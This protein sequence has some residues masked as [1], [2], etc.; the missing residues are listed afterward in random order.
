VDLPKYAKLENERRFLV[1]PDAGPDLTGAQFRLIE[2]LY[3][4]DSRLRL[5]ATTDSVTGIRELKFCK[6]YGSDDPVSG[7]ITNLYLTEAEHA[8][9]AV[10]PGARI[11]KRR[12]RVEAGGRSFGLDVFL[13]ALEGL[14]LCE[15]EAETRE[16]ALA[17]AFP[18][19]TRREVTHDPFFTGGSLCRIGADEL[20]VRLAALR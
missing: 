1:T 11:A 8:L 3:L 13:G 2:D 10:L 9:L 15:A 18:A 7:P 5:R 16:A 6:K 17:V 4:D 20:A 12:Y 19:W 14:R